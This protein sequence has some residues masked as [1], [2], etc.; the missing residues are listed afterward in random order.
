VVTAGVRR[1]EGVRVLDPAALLCLDGLC[2]SVI[3]DLL[4]YRNTGHLTVS[5]AETMSAWLGRK[6]PG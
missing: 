2:P 5:F 1:V 6:L 3:G 4:V